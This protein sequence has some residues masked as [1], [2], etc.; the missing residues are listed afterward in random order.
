MFCS[1]PLQVLTGSYGA[2]TS[3]FRYRYYIVFLR[4]VIQT[5]QKPTLKSC[6]FAAGWQRGTDGAAPTQVQCQRAG[7][8]GDLP[9]RRPGPGHQVGAG[10]HPDV[11][12]QVGAYAGVP[13]GPAEAVHDGTSEGQGPVRSGCVA[14]PARAR[15]QCGKSAGNVVGF[16]H[17][18]KE[19]W[20]G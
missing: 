5:V 2:L 12:R 6:C 19:A 9:G 13:T 7:A 18:A 11:P 14:L 1:I 15:F 16:A 10:L 8:A 3:C 17:L 20:S 4:A